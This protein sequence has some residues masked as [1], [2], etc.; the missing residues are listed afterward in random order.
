MGDAGCAAYRYLGG[1]AAAIFGLEATSQDA[2]GALG[3]RDEDLVD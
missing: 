3:E 2:W 1:V